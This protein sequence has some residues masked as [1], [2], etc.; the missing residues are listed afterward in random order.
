MPQVYLIPTLLAP[1]AHSRSFTPAHALH[2]PPLRYYFVENVRSARR[3]L[4]GMKL[5]LHISELEF[6]PMGKGSDWK[7]VS[8][9]FLSISQ[10]HSVGV[11]SEAGCPGIADPG[12]QLVAL[13]HRQSLEV[14]PLV[15]P[16]S[17]FLTLMASGL[18]GQSFTFLGY[19]PIQQGDRIAAIRQIEK[20]SRKLKQTQLFIETPY[21]NMAML[22]AL[23]QAAHPDTRL[24][25]GVDITSETGYVQTRSIQ[26]WQKHPP[27]IHKKPTTFALLA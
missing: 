8:E 26:S 3:F 24:C 18:N 12:A 13:A 11:L 20:T 22:K 10:E 27:D 23:W 7:S 2:I 21:R 6:I 17:I 9:Q 14:I 19:L 25:L 15:G 5:G 4:S 16:S 1:G